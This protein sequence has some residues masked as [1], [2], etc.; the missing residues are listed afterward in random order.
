M[1]LIIVLEG[2]VLLLE[3]ARQRIKKMEEDVK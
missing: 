2:A 1:Y 3:G